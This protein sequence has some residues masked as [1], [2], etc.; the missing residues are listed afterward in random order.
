M[1]T[2]QK[3]I[4]CIENAAMVS[5]YMD[6]V[7]FFLLHLRAVANLGSFDVMFIQ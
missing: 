1:K 2:V 5:K 4:H 6:V 3:A 7:L